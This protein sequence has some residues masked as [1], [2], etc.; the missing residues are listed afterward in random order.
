MALKLKMQ[1]SVLRT[2]LQSADKLVA[3]PKPVG[4]ETEQKYALTSCCLISETEQRESYPLTVA[5]RGCVWGMGQGLPHSIPSN[6]P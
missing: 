1:A 4:T 3:I 2:S 5:Q 6:K